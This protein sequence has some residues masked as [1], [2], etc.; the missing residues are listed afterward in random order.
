MTDHVGLEHQA[1]VGLAVLLPDIGSQLADNHHRIALAYARGHVLGQQTETAHLDPGGVAVTPSA[2]G[3]DARRAGQ[4]ERRNGSVATDL[5]LGSG[6]A[7][8]V[9]ECLHRLVLSLLTM[10]LRHQDVDATSD[11][12]VGTKSVDEA[13]RSC[14]PVDRSE[15]GVS[16]DVERREPVRPRPTTR[17]GQVTGRRA[18]EQLRLFVCSSAKM[19]SA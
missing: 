5:Y 1:L 8:D 15:E 9:Y 19:T 6:V 3:P 13:W 2:L 14:S 10:R 11:H 12:A 4:P 17:C 16:Q 7:R 18:S